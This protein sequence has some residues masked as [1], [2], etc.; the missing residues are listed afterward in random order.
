M[1]LWKQVMGQIWPVG[2]SFLIDPFIPKALVS[3]SYPV[4]SQLTVFPLIFL[5]TLCIFIFPLVSALLLSHSCLRL[6]FVLGFR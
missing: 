5:T 3:T 6:V 2:C 1:A 4:V